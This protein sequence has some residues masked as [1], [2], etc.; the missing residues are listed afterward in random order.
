MVAHNDERRAVIARKTSS[1][2]EAILLHNFI[3]IASLTIYTSIIIETTRS[4]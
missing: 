2:D 4:Q 1:A 3:G